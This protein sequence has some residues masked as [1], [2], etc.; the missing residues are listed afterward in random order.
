[1]D[2]K[3]LFRLDM[4]IAVEALD[5]DEAFDILITDDTLT[6]IKKLI[7]ESKETITEMFADEKEK[8]TILN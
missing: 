2:G 8:S 5:A 7:M 1:M 6:Q 4:S 3:K